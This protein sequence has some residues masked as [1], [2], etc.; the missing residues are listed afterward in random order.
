MIKLNE[1]YRFCPVLKILACFI[2]GSGPEPHQHDELRKTG[3]NIKT[4]IVGLYRYGNV[5]RP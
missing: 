2:V 5:G 3:Q 4:V 1:N